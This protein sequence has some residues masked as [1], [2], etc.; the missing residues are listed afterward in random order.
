MHFVIFGMHD[1]YF[2]II[3]IFCCRVLT[4]NDMDRH[5]VPRITLRCSNYILILGWTL[6]FNGLGKHNWE[7]IREIF[8]CWN[9]ALILEISRYIKQSEGR[10]EGWCC[11]I[12]A[13]N[14]T[15]RVNRSLIIQHQ[16]HVRGGTKD[17]WC[18]GLFDF[19]STKR[20]TSGVLPKSDFG[21]TM[22]KVRE[23]D[24]VFL[25]AVPVKSS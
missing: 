16:T 8:E 1:N 23:K 13:S 7:T 5:P 25:I 18:V 10:Y 20:Y 14:T 9:W 12:P 21:D 15:A 4:C 19:A 6:G 2:Y 3:W 22:S 17:A 11:C 24:R